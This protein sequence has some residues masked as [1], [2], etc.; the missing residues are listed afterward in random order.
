MSPHLTTKRVQPRYLHSSWLLWSF[1]YIISL[2]QCL[3]FGARRLTSLRKE[4]IEGDLALAEQPLAAKD[5]DQNENQRQ[6]DLAHPVKQRRIFDPPQRLS[7]QDDAH[8]PDHRPAD[9]P[10][11]AEDQHGD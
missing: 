5:N 7:Q 8:G 9:R 6:D 3:L 4:P 2:L 10:H 1:H 11:S